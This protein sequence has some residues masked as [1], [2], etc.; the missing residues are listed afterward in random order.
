MFVSPT[1]YLLSQRRTIFQ[2]G[3]HEHVCH[4]NFTASARPSLCEGLI[5]WTNLYLHCRSEKIIQ[6]LGGYTFFDKRQMYDSEWHKMDRH[7]VVHFL[8]TK[9]TVIMNCI[10]YN[11]KPLTIN[12]LYIF[13]FKKE[14]L[15]VYIV[16][17]KN[18]S[19]GTNMVPCYT[20]FLKSRM[21]CL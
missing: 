15:K 10:N 21:P 9:W 2:S 1:T 17:T 11:A 3:K 5:G 4:H 13:T 7:R 6:I 19:S 18:C 12:I 20:Y 16:M 8:C 14:F